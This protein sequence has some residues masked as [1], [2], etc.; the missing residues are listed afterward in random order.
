[1][2]DGYHSPIRPIQ[3]TW[4]SVFVLCIVGGICGGLLSFLTSQGKLWVRIVSG[5]IVGAVASWAY[6]F[7]G[8]P[9]ASAAIL[10]SQL[11]VLFVSLLAAFSGVKI[12]E[13]ITKKLNFGS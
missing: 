2:A 6:V 5:V 4:I 13:G 9:S 1:V 3:V 10:H 11:S 12:V 7:V 8:L